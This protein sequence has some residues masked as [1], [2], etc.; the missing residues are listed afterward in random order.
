MDYIMLDNIA[1]EYFANEPSGHDYTHVKNVLEYATQLQEKEGG[2]F[3]VIYVSALFHDVHRVISSKI[4][5]FV[6]PEDAMGEVRKLLSQ[7]EL[8]EDVYEDILYVISEHDNKVDDPFMSKELQIIQD[9]DILDALGERA[10]SRTYTY[11]K[12]HNIPVKNTAVPLDDPSF[13]PSVNPIS[14]THY[15]YRV[16]IPLCDRLHTSTAKK[17]AK[18]DLKVLYDFVEDNNK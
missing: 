8:E 6:A 2:D 1:R 3:D 14:M 11:C 5:R 9:A 17:L 18:Q 16:L 4:G 15:V 7:V 13:A 10:L 12:T